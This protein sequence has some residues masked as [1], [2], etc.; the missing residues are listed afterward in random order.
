MSFHTSYLLNLASIARGRQPERPLLFS[1]YLTHRCPMNCRYCSDGDGN[2]F[3]TTAVPEL[4]TEAA[5]RLITILSK[6]AD[7]LD[8]TGGEPMMR[9]DLEEILDHTRRQGMRSVL[10]TKG[11]GLASRPGLMQTNVLVLSIDSL[12]SEKL[13]QL[14][15]CTLQ[16]A[17]QVLEA[18]NFALTTR[19]RTKTQVVLSAVATPDNLEDIAEVLDFAVGHRLGFHLSPQI[20]GVRVNPALLASE[21]YLR[22]IG[23]VIKKKRAGD[24]VLGIREYLEGIRDF[25]PFRCHPLLMP[26]IRPDGKLVYPCLERPVTQVSILESGSYRE[27]LRRARAEYGPLPQCQDCC[28]IFCHMA[29]SLLQR[30]PLQALREGRHWAAIKTDGGE[31]TQEVGS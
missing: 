2:P 3:K 20:E 15:G 4:D 10:N 23:A 1:Y 8:V 18:L 16:M 13:A 26:V 22:L 12:R 7:T 9:P 29:L 27:A 14:H 31:V 19:S 24:G 11:I 17:G 6:S 5:K 25:Q 28:H 21:A 30:R